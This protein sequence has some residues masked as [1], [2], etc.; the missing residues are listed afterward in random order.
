MFKWRKLQEMFHNTVVDMGV[1]AGKFNDVH[2]EVAVPVL[3]GKRQVSYLWTVIE[4]SLLSWIA[5]G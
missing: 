4:E 2:K 3:D 1:E 5:H